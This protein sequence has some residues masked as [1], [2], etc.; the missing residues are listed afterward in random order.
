MASTF[1]SSS[2]RLLP[3]L[4]ML[5]ALLDFFRWWPRHDPGNLLFSVGLC[6]VAQNLFFYPTLAGKPTD[7]RGD[8][9]ALQMV[10]KFLSYAGPGV[11][12]L[13]FAM[14]WLS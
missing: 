2:R 5:L 9:T 10:S 14:P 11:A 12:L 1:P 6:L 7:S 3:G 13:G 8:A 4:L